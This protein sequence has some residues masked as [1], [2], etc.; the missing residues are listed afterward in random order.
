LED[1]AMDTIL[2]DRLAI[3]YP[4]PNVKV[5]TERLRLQ[6]YGGD[7]ILKTYDDLKD[8]SYGVKMIKKEVKRAEAK[9]QM[10]VDRRAKKRSA[11]ASSS[12]NTA[13]EDAAIDCYDTE[14]TSDPIPPPSN[15][16]AAMQKRRRPEKLVTRGRANRATRAR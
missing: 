4:G 2:Q 12:T 10:V 9:A 3:E 14:K 5:M 8:K 15:Q 11:V 6:H 13:A 7:G 1:D 16:L